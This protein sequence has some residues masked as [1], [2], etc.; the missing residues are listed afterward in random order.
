MNNFGDEAYRQLVARFEHL[1]HKWAGQWFP[2][3]RRVELMRALNTCIK[4]LGNGD[5]E[6]FLTTLENDPS[7]TLKKAVLQQVL[8]GETYFF[9]DKGLWDA[10]EDII[11]PDIIGQRIASR[12]M[13]IWSVGCST[14]E[15]PYSLALTV[16]RALTAIDSW[17]INILATDISD[18]ALA[19]ARIGLYGRRSLREVDLTR[20]GKWFNQFDNG[21]QI[22]ESVKQ[23]VNFQPCNLSELNFPDLKTMNSDLI[24]C[25]NVLIY[26]DQ[27]LVRQVITRFG[28]CLSPQ[29]WLI[30]APTEI[31][32]DPPEGLVLCP[33]SQNVV[34]LRPK[35]FQPSPIILP[36]AHNFAVPTT[37][38]CKSVDYSSG[39]I[40]LKN[41]PPSSF[42]SISNELTTRQPIRSDMLTGQGT[43]AAHPRVSANIELHPRLSVSG[44]PSHAPL[45]R[46]NSGSPNLLTPAK[47]AEAAP[48]PASTAP[49]NKTPAQPKSTLILAKEEADRG[50]LHEAMANASRYTKASP[51]DP[52][53]WLLLGTIQ[54][55]LKLYNKAAES[56]SRALYL[57]NTLAV[58]H[59]Y[60]A[61]VQTRLEMSGVALYLRN[62]HRLTSS[63]LPDMPLLYGD[64]LT[65]R[66]ARLIAEQ[67]D[68][69]SKRL[70]KAEDKE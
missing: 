13:R 63:L 69:F 58:A 57:D 11:I 34:A 6:T 16:M 5:G 1:L 67:I 23:H 66:N 65:M 8:I 30:L 56:L 3:S 42:T 52:Q 59:L 53:G 60:M 27:D 12:S 64:G 22:K 7:D 26:F 38:K 45:D 61:R 50:E 9:R 62:F 31:P 15:E 2:P 54:E 40:A 29:G 4:D 70:S 10:L 33:L 17:K 25:R 46:A 20:W 44:S 21:L 14:G 32:L 51:T 49:D 24:L 39:E 18:V 47:A 35:G 28:K 41:A 68:S 37:S 55:E 48:S 19:K 36:S 43:A